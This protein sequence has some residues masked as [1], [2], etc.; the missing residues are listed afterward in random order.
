MSRKRSRS[1]SRVSTKKN[2]SYPPFKLSPSNSS[3]VKYKYAYVWLLMKGDSYLPGIFTSVYSVKRT[4][5]N[6]INTVVMVTSDVSQTAR[7]VIKLVA[8]FIV[9]IEYISHK[10]TNVLTERQKELYGSWNDIAYTKWQ[11]LRL[12]FEKILFLDSDI[13]VLD[14]IDTLFKMKTPASTFASPFAYPL[15]RMNN[16]YT[17]KSNRKYIG[18]D[19]Y[20]VHNAP[21]TRE[22]M[23]GGLFKK[24]VTAT[25]TTILLK[26]SLKDFTSYMMMLHTMFKDGFG[27]DTCYSGVDEQ[28]IAY[29]YTFYSKGPKVEWTNIH[30]KYNYVG[31]WKKGYLYNEMPI[32]MHFISQP[33]PW[34]LKMDTYPDL[35][36]WYIMFVDGLEKYPNIVNYFED[37]CKNIDEEYWDDLK[38]LK[39]KCLK[40]DQ[41]YIRSFTEE[42]KSIKSGLDLLHKLSK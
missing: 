10:S 35:V 17:P 26:P 27:F 13:T 42:Y 24:G 8:D 30:H 12:P 18:K 15:G 33:K 5:P 40:A 29:Y 6:Q 4:S 7:E 3:I 28:S 25:A 19:G 41:S 22:M 39:E 14:N 37:V 36:N 2:S 31:I 11:S 20:P 16:Y 9:E 21:I 1:K 34:K 32:V 23:K 38:K